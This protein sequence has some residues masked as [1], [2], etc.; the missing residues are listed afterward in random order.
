MSTKCHS[1]RLGHITQGLVGEDLMGRGEV[2]CV[3]QA[4]CH[5]ITTVSPSYLG[6]SWVVMAT[7]VASIAITGS[8]TAG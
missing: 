1:I 4:S 3:A 7:V 8:I 2:Q 6:V 5:T